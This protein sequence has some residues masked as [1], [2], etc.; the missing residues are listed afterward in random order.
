MWRWAL[1]SKP[2]ISACVLSYTQV[3]IINLKLTLLV[4]DLKKF[5]GII[6]YI[7]T[8]IKHSLKKEK[9]QSYVLMHLDVIFSFTSYM[10]LGNKKVRI[11]TFKSL[12]VIL[13]QQI[14]RS[15]VERQYTLSSICLPL[16]P[17]WPG[18]GNS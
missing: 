4:L 15:S 12:Q 9:K 7:S 2:V 14:P 1:Q 3:E 11:F 18:E 5:E 8:R 16:G 6:I 10:F 17:G 13:N